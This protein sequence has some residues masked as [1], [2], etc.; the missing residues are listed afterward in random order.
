MC[1]D[2]FATFIVYFHVT[3]FLIVPI[4][5]RA[6][7]RDNWYNSLV[8]IIIA[9]IITLIITIMIWFGNCKIRATARDNLLNPAAK[10]LL[11]LNKKLRDVLNRM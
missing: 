4:K 11:A 9:I 6:K 10:S 3:I 7:A 1:R 2:F 5:I 8:I